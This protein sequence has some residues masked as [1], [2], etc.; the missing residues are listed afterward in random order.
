[1]IIQLLKLDKHFTTPIYC[2]ALITVLL[3]GAIPAKIVFT[4]CINIKKG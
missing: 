2:L 4:D 1:M 3:F